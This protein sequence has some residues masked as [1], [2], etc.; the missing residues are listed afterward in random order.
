[1]AEKRFIINDVKRH[2]RESS[3]AADFQGIPGLEVSREINGG[4][5][6]IVAVGNDEAE[7]SMNKICKSV[8]GC[9]CTPF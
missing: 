7:R 9:F 1:M 6:L 5:A 8:K 3:I 2:S 4:Q